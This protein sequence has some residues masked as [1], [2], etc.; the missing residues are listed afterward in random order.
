MLTLR[1]L[2]TPAPVTIAP[3]ATLR[4][5]VE[6]LAKVGVNALPVTDGDRIVG[7]ITTLSI[8]T[9]ESVMPGV[10]TGR[11]ASDVWEAEPPPEGD[12]VPAAEYFAE[13]WEDAGSDVDERFR[14]TDS[15][16]WDFLSEHRVDE[17]MVSEAIELSPEASVDEAV[18]RMKVTGAHGVLVVEHGKL[19]GIVTTMDVTRAFTEHPIPPTEIE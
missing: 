12:D 19:C 16:E 17:A 15:P 6:L 1:E 2:M 9:F 18:E 3:G 7:V 4:D 11:D 10:P 8:I 5:A 14:V 13:L